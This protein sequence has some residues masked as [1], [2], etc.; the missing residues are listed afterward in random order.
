LTG[1][2]LPDYRAVP[3]KNGW[4]PSIKR[5]VGERE[6]LVPYPDGPRYFETEAEAKAAAMEYMRA[7]LNTDIE[8]EQVAAEIELTEM[9]KWKMSKAEQAAAER[10][11]V[12]G[13]RDFHGNKVAVE[14]VKGRTV[15]VER[16]R[17]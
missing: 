17:A 8:A 14:R 3:T 1:D 6:K 4:R 13:V 15:V 10:L 16:R 5:F 12:F 11:K 9:Q 2:F 7:I